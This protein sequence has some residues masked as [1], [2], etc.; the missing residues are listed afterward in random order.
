MIGCVKDSQKIIEKTKTPRV[1]V[2]G[3]IPRK[4]AVWPSEVKE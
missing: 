1:T 3:E 4:P 2:K